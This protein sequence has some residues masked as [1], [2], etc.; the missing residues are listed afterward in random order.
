[1][2]NTEGMIALALALGLG[3]LVGLQRERHAEFAGIRT[4][5]LI[6]VLGATAGLLVAH[7]GGWV[8]AAAWLGLALLL[9]LGG[10]TAERSQGPVAGGLVDGGITTEIAALVMFGVGALLAAGLLAQG[11]VLGGAVAVLLH[12]KE[13]LHHFARGLGA[14]DFRAVIQFVLIA[15]VILP[16]LPDRAF[17]PYAVL[18]PYQVWLM[19]VLIV[20]INLSAYV[21]YRLVGSRGGALLGG[22]LG[23]LVSSTATSVSYA[24]QARAG[25]VQ[26][27]AAALVVVLASA[28]VYPR[29]LAEMVL[30]APALAGRAWLPLAITFVVMLSTVGLALLR[31][32]PE[33]VATSHSNPAQLPAALGFGLLYAVVLWVVAAGQSLFGQSAIYGVALIAGFTD[34]DAITLSSAQLVRDGQL[35]ADLAWRVVLL[36]SLSNL[37]FKFGIAAVLGP[38]ALLRH[39]LPG[40]AAG[41]LVGGGLILFW[42]SAPV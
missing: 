38:V 3:L 6:T 41:L 28:M 18:N 22:L 1:M 37:L 14:A 42:P 4:F 2:D 19:V 12:W 27:G 13:P 33:P 34:V 26:A 36:A 24:R 17:G 16:L 9:F 20:A 8:L 32:R 31:V 5:A 23:G 39:L 29:I 25:L 11:I 10:S 7:W 35:D 40:F 21:S 15:L 30:V